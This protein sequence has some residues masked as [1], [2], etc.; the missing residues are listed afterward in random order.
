MENTKF[1]AFNK[2]RKS[3]NINAVL[4]IHSQLEGT[5]IRICINEKNKYTQE[6]EQIFVEYPINSINYQ[7]YTHGKPSKIEEVKRVCFHAHYFRFDSHISTIL[8][9]IKE[10][11][12]TTLKIIAFNL[13][14]NHKE[15][16]FVKHDAYL[17][18]D[19]KTYMYDQFCGYD[20]SASPIQY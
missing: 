16:N 3:K 13:N 4:L 12:E 17:I 18:V 19:G 9:A 6:R 14:D 1:I 7:S 5:F 10:K 2:A 20:N 15:V 11:S 8:N